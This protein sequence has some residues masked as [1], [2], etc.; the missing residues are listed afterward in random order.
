MLIALVAYVVVFCL[1]ATIP[2]KCVCVVVCCF[3]CC[4]L[5]DYLL[6]VCFCCVVLFA[7]VC[8]LHVYSVLYFNLFFWIC[9]AYFWCNRR[10]RPPA[11]TWTSGLG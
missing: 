3:C 5:F 11:P 2:G 10:P 1:I 4:G 7:G 9:L 8:V 6:R